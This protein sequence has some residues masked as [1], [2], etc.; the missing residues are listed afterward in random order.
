MIIINHRVNTIEKLNATPKECG[1]EIDIRPYGNRLI[2]HHDPFQD[3]VDFEEWLKHYNHS[4]LVAETK[5]EGIE[6]KI[7]ELI[8]KH[9]IQNFFLL[10]VTPPFMVKYMNKGLTKM[11]GRFSEWEDIQTCL[12]LK[13][14][15]DWIF[16]DNFTKLPTDNNAFQKLREHFKICIVSPELLKRDEVEHTK[17]LLQEHPVDAVLTDHI[18]RWLP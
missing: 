2:L 3:G 11:A 13:G 10:S 5:S 16:I 1:V 17:Q 8:Q 9:N 6:E 12:N 4:L 14:K 18:E 7:L 15:A